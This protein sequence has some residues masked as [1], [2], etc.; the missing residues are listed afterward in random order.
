MDHARHETQYVAA[1]YVN[2]AEGA[3]ALRNSQRAAELAERAVELARR[4]GERAEERRALALLEQVR[5]GQQPEPTPDL[6]VLI[7]E[8]SRNLVA[9]LEQLASKLP[10]V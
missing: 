5:G 2:L 7:E 8:L 10:S 6:P 3:R 1:A 4:R 9:A